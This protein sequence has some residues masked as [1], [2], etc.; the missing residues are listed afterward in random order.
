MGTDQYLPNNVF[1]LKNFPHKWLFPQMATI[2]HH[3]GAGTTG[4]A[5]S[6]GVPN[7]IVPH[8]AD[9]HFWGKRVAALGAGPKPIPRKILTVERFAQAISTATHNPMMRERATAIGLEIVAEEGVNRAIQVIQKV[10]DP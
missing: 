2:V 3:G 5:L 6:S 10:M 7:V 9:Q 4:A 1:L 8:F